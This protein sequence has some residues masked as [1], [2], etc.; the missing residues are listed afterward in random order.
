VL[1][2]FRREHIAR[3]A[4]LHCKALTGL[5]S[6]M[7]PTATAAFYEGYL[8][9]PRCVAFVEEHDGAVRGFVLGS[10]D[11]EGMRRDALRANRLGI[12]RGIAASVLRRPSVLRLLADGAAGLRGVGFDPRTAELTYIAVREN[13]RGAGIG[14]AL[15][16]GFQSALR[17]QGI[18][19]YELSVE[20]DNHGAVAFYELRGLRHARTYRQF[21]TTYRRYALELRSHAGTEAQ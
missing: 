15:L 10:G 12:L 11:P 7:G 14:S 21:G 18:E 4:D 5:L 9:S 8:A 13:A 2:P 20:A 16:T 1:A 19:R 17:G 3:V 6:A